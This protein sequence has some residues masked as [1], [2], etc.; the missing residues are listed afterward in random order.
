MTFSHRIIAQINTQANHASETVLRILFDPRFTIGP[1]PTKLIIWNDKYIILNN[2]I[3]WISAVSFQIYTFKN[4]WMIIFDDFN[5]TFEISKCIAL[6]SVIW[7]V[8][9]EKNFWINKKLNRVYLLS[10]YYQVNQ[11][12]LL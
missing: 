1:N 4:I 12:K 3:T 8:I 5:N 10:S 7:L 2:A 6:W 11:H 9:N